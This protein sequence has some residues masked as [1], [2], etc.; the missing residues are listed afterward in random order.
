MWGNF[1]QELGISDTR[2]INHHFINQ[3]IIQSQINQYSRKHLVDGRTKRSRIERETL[4][5][6][7]VYVDFLN[8]LSSQ[9]LK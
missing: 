9:V 1:T 2:G 5:F 3:S 6:V 8:V 7:I 4:V